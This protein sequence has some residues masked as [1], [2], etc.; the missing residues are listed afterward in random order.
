MTAPEAKYGR[1]A[2]RLQPAMQKLGY[3]Q[4]SIAPKKSAMLAAKPLKGTYS[5]FLLFQG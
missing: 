2:R 5:P 3:H 4:K 1:S